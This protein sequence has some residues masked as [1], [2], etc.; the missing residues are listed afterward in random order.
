MIDAETGVTCTA[1]DEEHP[2]D[3][4]LRRKAQKRPLQLRAGDTV[5]LYI[6]NK[7]PFLQNYKFSS[8]DSQIKDDDIGTFLGMLVPGIGGGSGQKPSAGTSGAS[9]SAMSAMAKATHSTQLADTVS[10][11]PE[12]SE[13]V[14]SVIDQAKIDQDA[15][16]EALAMKL[17]EL[18]PA[19]PEKQVVASSLEKS[20]TTRQEINKK[21][22]QVL[23]KGKPPKQP[24]VTA[25]AGLLNERLDLLKSAAAAMQQP[26]SAATKVDKCVARVGSR[27]DNLVTNYGYFAQEYNRQ[28][29]FLLSRTR[30]CK[31]LSQTAVDLW[32]LISYEQ[33]KILDSRID[34]NLRDAM[35]AVTASMP[36]VD[37]E[38]KNKPASPD[39]T[40]LAADLKSLTGGICTLKAMRKE[41]ATVLSAAT[42]SMES[43]LINPNAFQSEIL[44]GPYADAT[45]VDWSLQR[46]MTQPPVKA[47]DTAAFNSA[48]DDCL[49]KGDG[50]SSP[51]QKPT[52]EKPKP[53]STESS[54]DRQRR[55]IGGGAFLVYASLTTSPRSNP[56][57]GEDGGQST[58]KKKPGKSEGEDG[59]A[60][61]GQESPPAQPG[62]S[63]TTT[64]GRRI[65]FGSERFIVSAGL[66]GT[67]LALRQFGKGVG[68]AVDATGK[69]V[70]GQ[71][72]ANIITLTTDQG[73]RLSPMVFLNTRLH[74]WSGRAEALYATFGITAK[75]DSNGVSPEYLLG[76]SQSFVQRHLL[77]TAGVYA[78][79]KQTLTGGLFVNEAIP[80]N[81]T[82]DIPTRSNYGVNVGF[83]I[84]WRIPG[85]AK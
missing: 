62:D 27:V 9:D 77:L 28:R 60:Q 14:K 18:H 8:T 24:D 64:R 51:V 67:P 43:V 59:T 69:P 42:G 4:S 55:P 66:T 83:S 79:R 21:E 61:K 31:E 75:S 81:L 15:A 70:S 65:N 7:N 3:G 29:N 23:Q 58:P 6:V 45:H 19:A 37:S 39:R 2:D 5:R 85:L 52:P 73:Y 12:G 49:S 46:T 32:R 30:S 35:A 25:I 1:T 17:E 20:A 33:A 22:S 72:T 36:P 53:G 48:L 68:Q 10:F 34:L 54:H 13:Q 47:V 74:Q 44:I 76:I 50:E 40:V 38:A 71:E 57:D 84:S 82:G 80:S 78:G 63:S 41:I 11:R 56:G 26:S 16:Q